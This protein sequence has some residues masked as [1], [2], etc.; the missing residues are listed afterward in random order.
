[1]TTTNILNI[2]GK[3]IYI[4]MSGIGCGWRLCRERDC[5]LDIQ[6]E[7]AAEI[8]DGGVEETEDFVAGNGIHYCWEN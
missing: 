8:L 4:D 3:T 2:A 1:M 5:P 6:E 7:I